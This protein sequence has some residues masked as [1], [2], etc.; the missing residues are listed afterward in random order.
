MIPPIPKMS[1]YPHGNGRHMGCDF[2]ERASLLGGFCAI[3]PD[4]SA[5]LPTHRPVHATE[6]RPD[7]LLLLHW[8]SQKS[9][10]MRCS[11]VSE[12]SLFNQGI[13]LT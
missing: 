11:R 1:N 7:A 3:A 12:K 8:N 4:W 2:G 13:L 9:D 5:S 6:A 10:R